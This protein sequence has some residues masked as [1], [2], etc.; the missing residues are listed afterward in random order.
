MPGSNAFDGQDCPICCQNLN[1]GTP[2]LVGKC[3]CK[4]HERC[5]TSRGE[6]LCFE[7]GEDFEDEVIL[8]TE[9]EKAQW[10]QNHPD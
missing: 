4:F 1:D 8:E 6:D 9:E 5:E 2:I 7:C 10:K 3:G